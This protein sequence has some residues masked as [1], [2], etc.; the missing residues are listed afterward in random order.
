[1]KKQSE[2]DPIYI[3]PFIE[4]NNITIARKE[5]PILK[6]LS[7]S[8]ADGQNVAILGP[9][10]SGK[11]SLIKVITREF[12]PVFE[13]N[14]SVCKIWG[15]DHWNV[16]DLRKKFGIV[17]SDLQFAFSQDIIGRNVLLSGFFSSVGLFNHKITDDMML[18]TKEIAS[19]LEIEHLMDRS[20][21]SLSS[22]EARRLLIGRALIHKPK[23]IILDEPTSSLDLSALHILRKYLRNIANVRV[24]I[25]LV[26]HQIHDIIPEI[27]RVIMMRNGQIFADGKKQDILTDEC[28]S[29]LFSV[30]VH[31]NKEGEYY[32]ATGY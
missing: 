24:G 15:R 4:F 9:N 22:G 32:Y 31:I 11:S 10:G 2:P 29:T 17:S 6:N 13:D 5:K 28:M 23:Y 7:L 14:K 18:R 12:Y 25:I 21:I 27:T 20:M 8:I 26:T 19:F 3:S 16:F 30:H 1:M